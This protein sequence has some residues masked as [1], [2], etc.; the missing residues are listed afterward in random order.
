MYNTKYIITN[1]NANG[2]RRQVPELTDFLIRHEIDACCVTETHL[3]VN[4]KFTIPG[5]RA[6]T[7]A[8]LGGPGGETAVLVRS[9]IPAAHEANDAG[10][11]NTSIITKIHNRTIR[12]VAAYSA[13]GK[14]ITKKDFE[15]ISKNDDTPTIIIG[16]FNALHSNWN[17]T[18]TNQKGKTLNEIVRS[19]NGA[20]CAPSIP[21]RYHNSGRG[22]T[23]D[24][25]T[26]FSW[27]WNVTSN[28]L[29]EL[30][31]DH[32]P[33]LIE[34]ENNA[35]TITPPTSERET[36]RIYWNRYRYYI[37]KENAGQTSLETDADID[38][39]IE[40]FNAGIHVALHKNTSTT[41]AQKYKNRLN[42]RQ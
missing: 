36:K 40:T 9:H 7:N 42:L 28:V 24:I 35:P 31:S 29:F 8:R 38:Q 22:N 32:Y 10:L 41:R 14:Q 2:V 4:E 3:R 5:Y 21:T 37:E 26:A 6:F 25:A 27:P 1:F 15:T 16:D 13:P 30:N 12:L 17:D 19:L 11:E 34:I 39:A 23:L 33:V 18:P 20:I